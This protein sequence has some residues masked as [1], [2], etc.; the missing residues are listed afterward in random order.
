MGFFEKWNPSADLERLRNEL[1]A[2][3]EQFGFDRGEFKTW[4]TASNRP[5]SESAIDGDNPLSQAGVDSDSIYRSNGLVLEGPAG[6]VHRVFP[7]PRLRAS[8]HALVRMFAD[9]LRR[10]A[11]GGIASS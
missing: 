11:G 5:A 7:D 3:L 9:F 1:D 10:E 8:E 6:F 4:P 2:L